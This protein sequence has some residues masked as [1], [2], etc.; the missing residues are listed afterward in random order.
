M[1]GTPM[2]RTFYKSDCGLVAWEHGPGIG[3]SNSD[4]NEAV[5]FDRIEAME[6]ALAML[7]LLAPELKEYLKTSVHKP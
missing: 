2:S 3:V 7:T 1:V 6:L 4:S 5:V